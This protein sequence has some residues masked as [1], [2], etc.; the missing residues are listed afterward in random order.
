[1]LVPR[2][3]REWL[4]YMQAFAKRCADAGINSGKTDRNY[5][6][7]WLARMH[8]IVEMRYQGIERLRVVADWGKDEL[9]AAMVP[10]MSEWLPTWMASPQ[11]NAR[12]SRQLLSTMSF[13]EHLEMLPCL[14][15]ILGALP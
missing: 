13:R 15:C 7:W 10:G 11:A 12:S 8:L 1:M 2:T 6:F 9:S 4:E 3:N 14:C 5:Q